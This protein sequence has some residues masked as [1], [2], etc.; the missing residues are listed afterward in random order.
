MHRS[1]DI[2]GKFVSSDDMFVG[3][4][5]ESPLSFTLVGFAY[6]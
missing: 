4:S 6:R 3:G 2:T 5:L 1:S